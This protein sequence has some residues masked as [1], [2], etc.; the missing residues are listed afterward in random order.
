MVLDVLKGN[1]Y[2]WRHPRHNRREFPRLFSGELRLSSIQGGQSAANK[3]L[4]ELDIT[5]YADQRS[6]VLPL[7]SR[8]STVLSPYI[9]HNLLTL[10]QVDRTVKGAPYKDREK[11]R[12]ELFW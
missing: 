5:Q 10:E 4:A 1:R 9:R 3:A 7:E 12:D 11:F 2:F 6:E 8:G